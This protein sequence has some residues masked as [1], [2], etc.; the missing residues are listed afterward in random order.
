[1]RRSISKDS[2]YASSCKDSVKVVAFSFMRLLFVAPTPRVLGVTYPST[3]EKTDGASHS[4]SA[5]FAEYG[6]ILTSL[7]GHFDVAKG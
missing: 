2:A 5:G 7:R 1:M 6:L 3:S 4:A